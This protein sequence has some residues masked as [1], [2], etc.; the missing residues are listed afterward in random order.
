MCQKQAPCFHSL[1]EMHVLGMVA[2]FC[3]LKWVMRSLFWLC[4]KIPT[5][6]KLFLPSPFSMTFIP[7]SWQK[8][9]ICLFGCW[10]DTPFATLPWWMLISSNNFHLVLILRMFLRGVRWKIS[11]NGFIGWNRATFK[12]TCFWARVEHFKNYILNKG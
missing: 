6:F 4:S 2:T 8:Y 7:L 9:F 1:E 11:C 5:P 12:S 3:H 10:S